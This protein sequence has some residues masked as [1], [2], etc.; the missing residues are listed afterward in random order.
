[1]K[2]II[3]RLF[4]FCLVV[5]ICF[6]LFSGCANPDIELITTDELPP[7]AVVVKD[8][9]YYHTGQHIELVR[10]GLMDGEITYAVPVTELPDINNRSNFGS[11]YEYQLW[12]DKHIDVVMADGWIRFC[13]GN[14]QQ[15][16]SQTLTEEIYSENINFVV[17]YDME[18]YDGTENE[19]C[20]YPLKDDMT[21]QK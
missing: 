19:I 20:H 12:D 2:S 18:Y 21:N 10:C 17:D 16:H 13:T 4:G 3:K 11:G 1:M 9:I 15:D 14:C 8:T 7:M 5:F 6:V